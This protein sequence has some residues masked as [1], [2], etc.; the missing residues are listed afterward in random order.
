MK[1]FLTNLSPAK[2]LRFCS[3]AFLIGVAV[4]SFLPVLL[5]K[6]LW[7]WSL[8]LSTLLITLFLIPRKY[9]IWTLMGLFFIVGIWRFG[10]SYNSSQAL[11]DLANG[12]YKGRAEIVEEP[13]WLAAGQGLIVRL[14]D[15]GR[16]PLVSVQTSYQQTYQAGQIIWLSCKLRKSEASLTYLRAR[17]LAS[18]CYQADVALLANKQSALGKLRKRLGASI[19]VSLI[20]PAAGLANAMLFGQRQDLSPSLVQAF[21]KS[22]LGHLIAISGM[23]ISLVIWLVM[24][25]ALACGLRRQRAYY[26]TV[27]LIA[28]FVLLVGASASVVRAALMGILVISAAQVGRLAN[29]NHILVISAAFMVMYDP[30]WLVFDLGFQ[31]SF[32]AILG[33]CSFYPGLAILFDRV[34]EKCPDWSKKAVEVVGLIAIATVSAQL[35]TLPLLVSRFAYL[36]VVSVPANV[37]AVWTMPIFMIAGLAAT[38]LT[39]ILPVGGLIFWLPVGILLNYLIRLAYYFSELS[40]ATWEIDDAWI[41][42]IFLIYIPEWFLFRYLAKI[43]KNS[44][45]NAGL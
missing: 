23:N 18:A 5:F 40:W 6:L 33:L 42:V 27:A 8:L 24:I 22:G 13:R 12:N 41:W 11:V 2:I 9:F 15:D 39:L 29:F 7:I 43:V 25:L 16:A 17:N 20:E 28:L 44:D 32:L 21:A 35:L 36:S 30:T 3:L 34:V 1:M 38:A 26:F 4:A 45:K 10:F 37:L 14:L 19:G 31:L